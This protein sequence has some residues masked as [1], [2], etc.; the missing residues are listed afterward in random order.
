[1]EAKN[2]TT[3]PSRIRR[4][5]AFL[6][7]GYSIRA[8]GDRRRQ[9]RARLRIARATSLWQSTRLHGA[10]RRIRDAVFMT[11][12]R[13]A[14]LLIA[15]LG[16]LST[17]RCLLLPLL[18]D[19]FPLLPLDGAAGVLLS[20]LSLLFSTYS[21]P[22]Y[23]AVTEDRLLSHLLFTTLSLPRPYIT[24]ARGLRAV[25][26]FLIGLLLAALSL[27]VSPFFLTL[28]LIGLPFL[29]LMLISPEL[30]LLLLGVFFPYAVL[31]PDPFVP[32][33]A[34]LGITLISYLFKLVL[35]K[36]DFSFEPIGFFLLLF[37]AVNLLFSLAGDHAALGEPLKLAAIAICGYFLAANLLTAKRSAILFS[38][39]MIFTAT[40]LSALSIFS[41]II[42][43]LPSN[44][45]HGRITSFL[46]EL[47][48][49]FFPTPSVL[50]VYLIL[51]LP[52]IVGILAD[53]K[54]ARLRLILQLPILLAA[55][56]LSISPM[57]LVA[58]ML[59][60]VL[61]TLLNTGSRT[62]IFFFICI[63][64]PNAVILLP[65]DLCAEIASFFPILDFDRM[66]TAQLTEL[67]SALATLKA[68]PFGVG[69][70]AKITE[71][72]LYLAVGMQSGIFGMVALVALLFFIAR[73]A[74][75][76]TNLERTNR[77]R[78]LPH[79]CAS[80]LFAALI[81]APFQNIFADIRTALL[82]F[83]TAGMLTAV[84]RIGWLEDELHRSHMQDDDHE[85]YATELR[86]AR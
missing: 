61:F 35:G 79:G 25:Y 81:Y 9:E 65:F 47:N 67:H 63:V 41:G 1:M 72:S 66:M 57:A 8:T 64:L 12:L 5:T 54:E 45:L 78:T 69:G 73:D 30:S 80:A 34:L 15:P 49:R 42:G 84:C 46:L 7:H 60:L 33:A 29:L 22:L 32:L 11:R 51:L 2:R 16:L 39:G 50:A 58:I 6:S 71:S 37:V 31:L 62:G 85:S 21:T 10:L 4:F 27:V 18:T 59:S 44:T 75:A 3:A 83:V 77:H 76:T 40:L 43:L 52:L 86:L 56:V 26:P 23:L 28:L 74:I 70:A 20:L 13:A 24:M 17:F 55:L 48:S 82:F 14:A 19:D 38:R 68:H 36:R 53:R